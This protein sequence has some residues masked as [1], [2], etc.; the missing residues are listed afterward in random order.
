MRGAV[1]DASFPPWKVAV[2]V[3]RCL[4]LVLV[5]AC[6]PPGPVSTGGPAG[7][8]WVSCSWVGFPLVLWV[9]AILHENTPWRLA[10]IHAGDWLAKLLAV[11]VIVGAW[12]GYWP[13]GGK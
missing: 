10:A 13:A 1:L 11:A 9:G 4:I 2:E 8:C 3:G 6:S 12:P 7:C 5:V